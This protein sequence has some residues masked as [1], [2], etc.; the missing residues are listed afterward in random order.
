MKN[1]PIYFKDRLIVS[2]LNSQVAIT[3]LWT[4]K[5]TVEKLIPKNSY[6]LMGQLYTKKGINYILRNIL[7]NPF[8]TKI[9][10][11]GND[12]MNSGD[13]FLKLKSDGIDSNHLIAGDSTSQIE[14]EISKKAI[15]D[16]RKNVEIVDL[17]GADNLIKLEEKLAKTSTLSKKPKLW[18]KA[19]L[20]KT[21]IQPQISTYPSEMD[22]IKIRRDTIASA[23]LSVLK[24]V[25]MFGVESE[26]V[27][28][29]VSDTSNKLKE[30]LNLSVVITD[31]DPNK[32]YL[33]KYLPFTKDDLEK[34][35]EGFFNHEKGTEDYTYGER[36]FNYASNEI[37]ALK[38]IY[39][40][41]KIDRFQKHFKNGGLDQVAISIV[42]KLKSFKYDKGAIALLAN[43]F[44][45]I[46]PQRPP[47][48]IPCL[49]LI[50]CQIYQNK[51][52]MT[53]YFRSNDM[54]G[55]WPLNVFALRK[56]Q[57]DI[58]QKLNV[59]LGPLIT[60]SNMA[61]IYE[62]DFNAA[63]ELVDKYYESYC[64]WDPRGNF[65]IEVIKN[66]IHVKLMSPEGNEE[67]NKWE[68]NGTEKNA[69]RKLCSII[70]SD[71][72]VSCIGNA[73]Y[74]GRQLERAEIAV[75][76]KI[77]YKQDQSLGV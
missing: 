69:S 2:N 32:W 70:E 38:E 72:G 74:L 35:F 24:H 62:H 14:K 57:A 50:Q 52:N 77:S 43:P 59:S 67:I 17:R 55:A 15:E 44:T 29:Y 16:F 37:K 3:T 28:S 58:A 26:P 73:M 61:Q 6:A 65:I 63:Q 49:F 54:F 30:L 11:V 21:P 33:P 71:L 46:F 23:Y 53:A 9:Y 42:R 27:M 36:L 39:P 64:E 1:W 18:R 41:M 76:L 20:F 10:L 7:S 66:I 31:E 22:L 47:K 75:R 51:L 5:E 19:E 4:P 56:L 68:I 48:K 25:G 60:I 12:L 8:I 34:Y 45:D 13:S 40:Y